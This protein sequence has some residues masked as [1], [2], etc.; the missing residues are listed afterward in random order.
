[1]SD[2]DPDDVTC[3]VRAVA[4]EVPE[5]LL[6]DSASGSTTY[7]DADGIIDETIAGLRRRGLSR[8]DRI[9]ILAPN[10]ASYVLLLLALWRMGAVA[11]PLN[12]R[13]PWAGLSDYLRMLRVAAVVSDAA[14]TS[15]PPGAIPLSVTVRASDTRTSS[16]ARIRTSDL[17]AIIATSGSSGIPKGVALCYR[18]LYR[19]A[20]GS[21]QNIPLRRGDGWVLSL[22]LYHVGGLG[23]IF[24]CIAA[25]ATVV[26]PEGGAIVTGDAIR[27][28]A[29]HLSLV[30]TQLRRLLDDERGREM[31]RG[32]KAVLLGGAPMPRTLIDDSVAQAIPIH[33]SYG[34]SEMASQVT[35]TPPDPTGEDLHT[36]GR[37]LA[38]R[39]L[40]ISTEGEIL[41]RGDTLFSGYVDES[42]L[43]LPVDSGGWFHT[44]D[45]GALDAEDRLIVRGRLDN[46]FISGG[47]NIQPEEIERAL[48]SLG[49]VEEALVVPVRDETFGE[50]PAAFV[51]LREDLMNPDQLREALR[52]RLPGYMIPVAIHAWPESEGE[53]WKPDR[54]RFRRIAAE[55]WARTRRDPEG[56]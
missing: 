48:L 16:A 14:D 18:S 46:Q 30:P 25:G 1:M 51:R 15:A 33:L 27:T 38:H 8:G 9:A 53:I 52:R 6:F 45:L 49:A 17:A 3:P 28:R 32:T 39:Q 35:T 41:V 29:T 43:R 44:R 50:R 34:L 4:A 24:R 37:L 21:N 23:I 12:A 47:E 20:L 42:G 31:L 13:R 40:R 11:C 7:G 2:A 55:A 10:G 22:P 19:S 5:A 56:S 26:L 54:S 36:S